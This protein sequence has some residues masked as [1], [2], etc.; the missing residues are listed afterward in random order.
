M[1]KL[2]FIIVNVSRL[3]NIMGGGD[4][5]F[6]TGICRLASSA[7][8]G[9]NKTLHSRLQRG[10]PAKNRWHRSNC[11]APILGTIVVDDNETGADTLVFRDDLVLISAL[12]QYFL[13]N[14]SMPFITSKSGRTIAFNPRWESAARASRS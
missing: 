5:H 1:W 9:K 8:R 10:A 12:Q 13:V 14:V 3:T 7:G 4:D 6:T 2:T 11:L